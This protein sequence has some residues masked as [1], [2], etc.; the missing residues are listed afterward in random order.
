M[1]TQSVDIDLAMLQAS[2]NT[3]MN[4]PPTVSTA[5]LAALTDGANNPFTL[6]GGWPGDTYW[7]AAES[8]RLACNPGGMCVQPG[9]HAWRGVER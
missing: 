7:E 5:D 1:T 8:E 4:G 6:D 3:Q 9:C 2:P